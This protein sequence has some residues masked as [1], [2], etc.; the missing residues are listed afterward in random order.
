MV[1]HDAL[2]DDAGD[3]TIDARYIKRVVDE[4]VRALGEVNQIVGIVSN[5]ICNNYLS[6]RRAN[7]PRPRS[8]ARSEEDQ[9]CLGALP[10]AAT[11]KPCC[12]RQRCGASQKRPPVHVPSH[13]SPLFSPLSGRPAPNTY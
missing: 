3:Q 4:N 12:A 6:R 13:V 2:L 5:V 9:P 1:R 8:A 7:I 10:L 11:R